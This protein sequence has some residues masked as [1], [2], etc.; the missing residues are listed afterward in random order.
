MMRVVVLALI[1][2]MGGCIPDEDEIIDGCREVIDTTLPE[3]Y[4]Q[5]GPTA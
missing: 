1:V 5:I 3:V 4:E 2:L